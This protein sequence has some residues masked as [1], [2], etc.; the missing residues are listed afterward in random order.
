MGGATRLDPRGAQLPMAHGSR[1]RRAAVRMEDALLDVPAEARQAPA[2]LDD[3]GAARASDRALPLAQPSALG[4]RDVPTP[5][6]TG[7]LYDRREPSRGAEA[8]R[9]RGAI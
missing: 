8:A 6:L 9:Q 4:A 3:P 2:G 7:G 1:R 5:D